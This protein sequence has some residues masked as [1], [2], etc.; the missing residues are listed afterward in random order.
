MVQSQTSK[1]VDPFHGMSILS[2]HPRTFPDSKASLKSNDLDAIHQYMSSL[3]LQ[4]PDKHFE[5]AKSIIDGVSEFMNTKEN[6]E[7]DMKENENPQ[8]NRP[9]LARKRAKFSMKPD[10]RQPS[11]V[12]EPTFQMD[13]LHDPEEF[14]A[15]YDKFENTIKELKRQKG[16]DPNEPI[17]P[18]N[19]RQRRP[20]IPRRK[21]SYQHHVYS[22][23]PENNALSSQEAPQNTIESQP[24]H[25][26]QHETVS[27]N[28]K[29]KEKEVAG[30]VTNAEDRVNKLFDDLMSSDIADLDE[31]E[32][33]SYLQDR[34]KIKP[35]SINDLQ[36]PNIHD[37]PK[38]NLF[39]SVNL[40]KDQNL[41]PDTFTL[42]DNLKE[43]T[44]G[45]Q[46][47][48]SDKSFNPLSSPTP[49]RSPFL[50]IS[51]FGKLLSKSIEVES[52]DPFSSRDINLFPTTIT[53]ETNS[54]PST[55]VSK[56]KEF[57]VSASKDNLED[58][59]RGHNVEEMDEDI[60]GNA[61]DMMEKAASPTKCN[62]NVEDITDNLHCERDI[63][64]NEHPNTSTNKRKKTIATKASKGA[65]LLGQLV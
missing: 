53:S 19:A 27:P 28:R 12:L 55:H 24:M 7:P 15:A 57:S 54:G 35:V 46:K 63:G 14:F 21:V 61:E 60:H 11:T 42:S 8:K 33:V 10:T 58:L 38:V 6:T 50:A 13:Q 62:L 59:E 18:A 56:D 3:V 30:S 2:L 41:L 40:I 20:E 22:S 26:S 44:P 36:L 43:N 39:S 9:A 45:K 5:E 29:S 37:I 4:N 34:L 64:E 65:G 31:N 16:E 47:K 23:Q 51:T 32:A 49:S 52:V 48:F 17:I 25:D 1:P